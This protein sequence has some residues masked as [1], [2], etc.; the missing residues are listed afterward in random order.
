M[1]DLPTEIVFVFVS[2]VCVWAVAS[3]DE[4]IQL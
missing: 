4:L 1:G 3:Q 2:A